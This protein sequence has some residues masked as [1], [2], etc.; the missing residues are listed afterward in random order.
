MQKGVF[1]I[2]VEID[3]RDI[4]RIR[5]NTSIFKGL[6][7]CRREIAFILY[8]VETL[9]FTDSITNDFI[10]GLYNQRVIKLLLLFSHW[11]RFLNKY[12]NKRF[13]R[14]FIKEHGIVIANDIDDTI[15]LSHDSML[16]LISNYN[17]S[18]RNTAGREVDYSGTFQM[19]NINFFSTE[20]FTYFGRFIRVTA[21]ACLSHGD[22]NR[23]YRYA[24]IGYEYSMRLKLVNVENH[25]I[26]SRLMSSSFRLRILL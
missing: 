19:I 10:V 18:R 21:S 2:K 24:L 11:R 20:Y 13:N 26:C 25:L 12:H 4:N 6:V 7:R 23:F 3:I 22:I 9:F 14:Q 8:R 5:E 15:N 1:Q 17:S 16:G